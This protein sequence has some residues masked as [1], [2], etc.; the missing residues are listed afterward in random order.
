LQYLSRHL[1]NTLNMWIAA[2]V[3]LL[4]YL[5]INV[6]KMLIFSALIAVCRRLI[7]NLWNSWYRSTYIKWEG[8]VQFY[9]LQ[10]DIRTFFPIP[11][12]DTHTFILIYRYFIMYYKLSMVLRIDSF[13]QE[14]IVHWR[15]NQVSFGYF[16]SLLHQNI[17][18]ETQSSNFFSFWW[19]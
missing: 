12:L 8:Y 4:V 19:Y 17:S 2:L 11:K 5:C 3:C 6:R 13:P 7:F 14:F 18:S 10:Y 15:G 1:A 16:L 9:S